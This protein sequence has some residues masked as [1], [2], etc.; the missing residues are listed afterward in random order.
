MEGKGGK[1]FIQSPC[2]YKRVCGKASVSRRGKTTMSHSNKE[3][4]LCPN[5]FLWDTSDDNDDDDVLCQEPNGLKNAKAL[6]RPRPPPRSKGQISS[7]PS[8]S[9]SPRACAPISSSNQLLR[10]SGSSSES[11]T[12][13]EF[14]NFLVRMKS[15]G[16]KKTLSLSTTSLDCFI[17]EDHIELSGNED[18]YHPA[19]SVLATSGVESR[20]NACLLSRSLPDNDSP[21]SKGPLHPVLHRNKIRPSHQGG[22]PLLPTS[23]GTRTPITRPH[24]PSHSNAK[25]SP[26]KPS[27]GARVQ[28][29]PTVVRARFES[30]TSV[31]SDSS[32]DGE[33]ETL[34]LCIRGCMSS[35]HKPGVVRARFESP[36]LVLSDSSSDGELENLPL[37]IRACM[38]SNH[39]PVD[40][41]IFGCSVSSEVA[42]NG[43]MEPTTGASKKKSK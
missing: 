18:F 16:E 23:R 28:G 37:C 4:T 13:V 29:P 34:P 36:T 19:R 21:V 22:S 12:D 10:G 8:S 25:H 35:N 27:S 17:V 33:L 5:A 24:L 15:L 39:K 11:F 7:L 2:T 1:R 43:V 30:P 32:S 38:G 9:S 3:N 20:G 40:Q 26:I 31:L 41:S 6:P 42:G 14:E